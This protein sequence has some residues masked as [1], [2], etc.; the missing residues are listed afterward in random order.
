[1]SVDIIPFFKMRNDSLSKRTQV[2]KSN[3]RYMNFI[4]QRQASKLAMISEL[5]GMGPLLRRTYLFTL[6]T[7]ISERPHDSKALQ[8]RMSLDYVLSLW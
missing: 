4:W 8:R 6:P 5:R 3:M 1:M 7:K 2:S